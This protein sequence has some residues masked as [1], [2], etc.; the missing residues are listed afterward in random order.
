MPGL[1][2]NDLGLQSMRTD[3]SV[4]FR[5]DGTELKLSTSDAKAVLDRLIVICV[6]VGIT[7]YFVKR[8]CTTKSGQ[9]LRRGDTVCANTF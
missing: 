8:D 9:H 4:N 6:I 7:Y 1:G 5:P 2:A 3:L